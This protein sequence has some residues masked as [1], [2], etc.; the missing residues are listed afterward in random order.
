MNLLFWRPR[1]ASGYREANE[2]FPLPV[3]IPETGRYLPPVAGDSIPRQ[4]QIPG[5]GTA[6]AYADGDAFGTL[7]FIPTLFRPEK[8]SGVIVKALL[9]DKDDE[10]LQV[11]LVFFSREITGTTDNSAFNPSDA[12]MHSWEGTLSVSTFYNWSGNQGGQ[13]IDNRL[14]VQSETTGIWCQCVARG[15]LNIAAGALPWLKLTV[16]P[17]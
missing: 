8:R 6:S 10:G 7:F 16:V 11:D 3:Q 12:D 1:L 4:I 13:Q 9:V 5:I 2:E 17:N 14:W 15:A